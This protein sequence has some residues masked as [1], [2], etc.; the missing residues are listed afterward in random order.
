MTSAETFRRETMGSL[1]SLCILFGVMITVCC[2]SPGERFTFFNLSFPVCF[3]VRKV[4]CLTLTVKLKQLNLG[5]ILHME[6]LLFSQ[7]LELD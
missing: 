5:M 4:F 1:L 6:Y 2:E 3:S 7:S